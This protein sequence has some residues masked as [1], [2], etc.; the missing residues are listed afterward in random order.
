MKTILF[1]LSVFLVHL[2]GQAQFFQIYNH[3]VLDSFSGFSDI[4]VDS[5]SIQVVGGSGYLPMRSPLLI[6]EIEDNGYINNIFTGNN[7]DTTI[8]ITTA[9]GTKLFKNYRGNYMVF[10]VDLHANQSYLKCMEA[11]ENGN[12]VH[13][14]IFTQYPLVVNHY[15]PYTLRTLQNLDSTFTLLVNSARPTTDT[16]YIKSSIDFIKITDDFEIEQIKNV[17]LT[18]EKEG[19]RL[20]KI[21]NRNNGNILITYNFIEFEVQN[22]ASYM[23]IKEFDSNLNLVFSKKIN[24]TLKNLGGYGLL[25]L[26]TAVV[27]TFSNS[28]I[29]VQ[30]T[31]YDFNLFCYSFNADS[32]VWKKNLIPFHL[33]SLGSETLVN[34]L[35]LNKNNEIVLSLSRYEPGDSLTHR[36]FELQNRTVY[37]DLNWA[38][39]YKHYGDNSVTYCTYR[40]VVYNNEIYG[41]GKLLN[42]NFYLEGKPYEF[43]YV[44]K[45]NCL[46]YLD[47]PELDIQTSITENQLIIQNNSSYFDSLFIDYGD[48]ITQIVHNSTDT[49][50]HIYEVGGEYELRI[51]PITCDAGL[52]TSYLQK[53]QIDISPNGLLIY[54]NPSSGIYTLEYKFFQP[55]AKFVV[56]DLKG[57][58]VHRSTLPGTNGNH[59]LD[60]SHIATGV[61]LLEVEGDNTTESYKIVKQ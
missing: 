5:N 12:L 50:K 40:I 60:L 37:G 26:D 42:H 34:D 39:N 33:T 31:F 3:Q 6:E 13:D 24:P 55:N 20:G 23:F 28:S 22:G 18:D 38:R 36:T 30:N 14:T 11:D 10:F 2:S 48:G 27:F 57:K 15:Q 17:Q 21:L 61:Y 43:A 1:I 51:K 52:D 8:Q 44:F 56:F 46:G 4:V 29:G 9:N 47:A 45:T 35:V 58:L 59:V 49:I 7:S 19:F 41:C 16:S 53:I 25:D 32:I 54:P